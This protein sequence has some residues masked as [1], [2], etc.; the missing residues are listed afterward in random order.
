M[1]EFA[2]MAQQSRHCAQCRVARPIKDYHGARFRGL[3]G[4]VDLRV[5]RY[6]KC[7]C[8]LPPQGAAPAGSWPCRQRWISTELGCVQNELA[9]TVS[10]GRSAQI[11]HML[12]PVGSDHSASTVQ[13][14]TLRVGRMESELAMIA[15][16]PK[17][18][19]AVTTVGLDGGY[20]VIAVP[21]RK[22]RSRSLRDGCSPRT[23][24]SVTWALCAPLTN[25][26]ACACNALSPNRAGPEMD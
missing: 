9:A 6:V 25:T 24:R 26:R 23:A 3:F 12:L 20:F 19:S 10:C 1:R 22:N 5:P 15:G 8:V 14:R 11:L 18:Q 7:G 13:D 17:H 21:T 2:T 4:D 16:S